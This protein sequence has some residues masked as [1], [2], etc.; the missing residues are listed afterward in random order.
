MC[1]DIV[2]IKLKTRVVHRLEYLNENYL[3]CYQENGIKEIVLSNGIIIKVS[4]NTSSKMFFNIVHTQYT[5]HIQHL[6]SISCKS[7]MFRIIIEI[8]A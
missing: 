4:L 7:S 2:S 1:Y 3:I 5:I 8:A 6:E